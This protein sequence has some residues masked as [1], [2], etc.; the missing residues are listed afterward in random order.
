MYYS[1]LKAAKTAF[2]SDKGKLFGP[3]GSPERKDLEAYG[4]RLNQTAFIF[5]IGFNVSSALVN[6][7]QVPLFVMPFLGGKYGY[8]ET[9]VA[10]KEAGSLVVSSGN[11]ILEN[12]ETTTSV[13]TV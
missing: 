2:D 4:R 12:Y 7:S 9:G 5:T 8:K 3:E 11:S 6:L 13:T 1:M 10:I